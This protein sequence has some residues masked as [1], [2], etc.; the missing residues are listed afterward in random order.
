MAFVSVAV[1]VCA[2]AGGA[3][4]PSPSFQRPVAVAALLPAQRAEHLAQGSAV[5]REQWGA[6]LK[7]AQGIS[8]AKLRTAVVEVLKSPNPT[9]LPLDVQDQEERLKG[10][11]DAGLVDASVKVDAA[12]PSLATRQ[13]F[14]ASPGSTLDGHHAHPGGLVEH[15]YFNLLAA[16][17]LSRAYEASAGVKVKD[18]VVTAAVLLH[19]AMKPYVLQ[20]QADGTMLVQPS[21]AGTASH[22]I[23]AIAEAMHRGLSNEVVVALAAA[24]DPPGTAEARV[25][26]FLRAGALLAGVDPVARGLL[27]LGPDG[28]PKLAA[29]TS[30]EAA[31][32]H[33]ADHDYVLSEPAAHLV[34]ATLDRLIRAATRAPTTDV[35][36]RWARYRIEA[37]VPAVKLYEALLAGGDAAVQRELVQAK[38][39]LMAPSATE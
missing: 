15:T 19:D 32:S 36:V 34:A 26:G 22:H 28:K 7:A 14:V 31:I 20:W 4:P 8:D 33:L 17:G 18:D 21:I 35:A 12:F 3:S 11:V 5:V 2:L 24:H 27:V 39:P 23:Y 29:P 9:F 37:Q 6:L 10:L 1:L 30:F 13:S 16:Q 25:V 38:V